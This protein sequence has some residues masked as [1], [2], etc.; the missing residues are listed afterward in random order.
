MGERNPT[1]ET[2]RPLSVP[3]LVAH[4]KRGYEDR[5]RSI[6]RQFGD[7]GMPF[8]FMLDGDIPD[9]DAELSARWF[10]PRFP[11]GPAQS[12]ACKHLL[13]YERIAA[14]GWKGALILEDD[15]FLLEGF[16]RVFEASLEELR[17][18]DGAALDTAWISYENTGHVVPPRREMR[19]GQM[20][21]RSTTTRCTGAYYIGFAAA[22]A[23]LHEA[24]TRKVDKAIDCWVEDM[25][26]ILPDRLQIYWCHPAVAEQG[27]MNGRFDSMDTRRRAGLW[28]RLKW[29]A[30]KVYKSCLARFTS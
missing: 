17:R 14:A 9:I 16:A 30:D 12:C 7:L 24:S 10:D 22:A 5:R 18:R 26:P 28:R 4:V 6:E 1:S 13:M 25:V 20:L 2:P 15:I 23:L 11:S 3:V 8:E 19:P 27:S 29:H 21:Y